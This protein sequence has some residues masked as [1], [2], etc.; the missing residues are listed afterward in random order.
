MILRKMLQRA[1][2]GTAIGVIALAAVLPTLPC[3]AQPLKVILDTRFDGAAA[4]FFM[5]VDKGYVK[6]E[7]LDVVFDTASTAETLSR[8]AS[9]ARD[10]G[11]GDINAL[12]RFRDQTPNAPVVAV[13]MVASKPGYAVIGRKSR[14]FATA[15]DLAGKRLGA[16]LADPAFAHWPQFAAANGIDPATVT[17]V[18]VGAAVLEPMVASGEL[19]AMIGLSYMAAANLKDR[20]VPADDIAVLL[21]ADRGVELYGNAIF[22]NA[23][24]AAERPEA[25]RAF[26]RAFAKGLQET[27]RR[28][29]AAIDGV[30]RRSETARKDV[31]LDRLTLFLRDCVLAPEA[32]AN[33]FGPI[34]ADRFARAVDRLAAAIPF[35]NGKPKPEDIFDPSFLPP[36]P[37][38]KIN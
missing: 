17:I 20:G 12:M 27:V 14:G 21:M 37:A 2:R 19:D 4:P 28:P 22:A 25:L 6:A 30:I 8:V 16:P 35:K 26:L 23:R 29:A 24:F 3:L 9:G 38:R 5:A 18:N 34:E 13:F 31:E 15:Q 36:L 7:N 11:Y 1:R 33:G 10:I 32:K